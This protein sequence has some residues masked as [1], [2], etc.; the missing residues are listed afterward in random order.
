MS[1]A[2]HRFEP[3]IEQPKY[4]NPSGNDPMFD[5]ITIGGKL[6]YKSFV[7]SEL[8]LKIA[9]ADVQRRP[10]DAP[11]IQERKTLDTITIGLLPPITYE[12]TVQNRL[13][14]YEVGPHVSEV[15]PGELFDPAKMTYLPA[16]LK[17]HGTANIIVVEL[18]AIWSPEVENEIMKHLRNAHFRPDKQP[19]HLYGERFRHHAILINR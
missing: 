16:A 8:T 13:P 7:S 1:H 2:H 10:N 3:E 15:I 14:T 17:R 5:V 18:G 11:I 19:Y 12:P 6:E 9:V 4:I